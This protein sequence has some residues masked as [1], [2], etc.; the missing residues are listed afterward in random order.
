LSGLFCDVSAVEVAAPKAFEVKRDVA[1]ASSSDGCD[2][3]V[4]LGDDAC[5][6][7]RFDFDPCCVAVMA[8]SHLGEPEPV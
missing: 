4:P 6:V 2:H 5:E 8:Y 1:V 3:L 7:I